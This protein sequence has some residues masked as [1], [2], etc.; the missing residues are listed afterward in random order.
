MARGA[1][2]R[3]PGLVLTDHV[4][5]LPLDHARP[6]GERIDVFAREAAAAE[7]GERPWL[8]YF[9]GG[10]GHESPRPTAPDSPAWLERALEDFRVLLLD[11][12]GTGLSSP[13]THET[14]AGLEPAEQAVYLRHFR[15]DSIV[16][17]AE[18]IRAEVESP[19]WSV[20][21]QSFGGF[22]VTCYLSLAAEGLREALVTGGLPPLD[23]GP[24]DVYRATYR[25]V[26]EKNRAFY[27]RY[28]QD[29]DR[30]RALVERLGAEDVR[31]PDGDRLTVRRFR[32]LGMALGTSDG[33]EELHYL[34]ERPFGYGFL[35][36][37]AAAAEY[38]TNPIFAL[39]HEAEYS[40]GPATRWSAERILAEVPE[41]EDETLFFGE[42]IFP[43]IFE[44]YGLLRPLSEAANLLAE[45]DD[46]ELLYDLDRLRANEVPVAAAVYADDMYVVRAYSE[47][48]ART[49][50]GTQVWL[51]N[52]YE[53]N[54]L[55]ADGRRILDRLLALARGETVS[56]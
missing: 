34:L 30:V 51:T 22:C 4:F 29:R 20:L 40:Q 43:W 19:P 10:P 33:A 50:R 49:I 46:W 54:G 47:E 8:V 15:A 2:H 31:L 35:R 17:D 55:R 32:Q 21:G 23:R 27:E 41:F 7:G 39:L 45:I 52:E 18:L 9:Q 14:L 44:D 56:G 11:Q 1:V 48:T 38:V 28:P 26:Q 6:D 24:D 13:A 12:R 16:R 5:S 3:L 37:V 53:H 42:T 25:I 36:A